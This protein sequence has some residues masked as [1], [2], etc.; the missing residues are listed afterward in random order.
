MRGQ[1]V[2]I[3]LLCAVPTALADQPILTD[4][5][6]Q[7]EIRNMHWVK[8]GAV[9]LATSKSSVRLPTGYMMISDREARRFDFLTNAQEDPNTEAVVVNRQNSNL[10]FFQ[11]IDDGFITTDDWS[12]VDAAKMLND[13][14]DNT[15]QANAERRK[16]NLEELHVVRWLQQ[17]TFDRPSNVV[18]WALLLTSTSGDLVNATALRLGRYG[19]EEQIWVTDLPA[20][21]AGPD[22]QKA[23]LQAHSF[24]AGARYEDHL[25]NDKMAGYGIASLVAVAAGAKL[26]KA[27]GLGVLLVLAKK[28]GIIIL[29]ALGGGIAWV[30]RK[31]TRKAGT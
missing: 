31:F 20:Y 13:I 2:A 11:Y 1:L 3:A 4:Q 19:Y 7:D 6:R 23:M 29:A 5:Q 25:G 9:D 18:F 28:F 30:K 17:P 14:R 26:A 24:N 27:A 21:K 22:D 10:V 8:S 12:D 16:Q 15:E